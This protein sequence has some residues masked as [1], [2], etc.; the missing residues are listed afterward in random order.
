MA[1]K[2]RRKVGFMVYFPPEILD[3]IE[4]R[5][6]ERGRSAWI[7]AACVEKLKRE[8]NRPAAHERGTE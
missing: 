6:E 3:E 4:A 5:T 2:S 8:A 1:K 7:V